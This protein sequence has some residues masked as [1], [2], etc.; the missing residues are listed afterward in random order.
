MW[1]FNIRKF[2]VALITLFKR[3]KTM[4]FNDKIAKRSINILRQL[5]KN[6][7]KVSMLGLGC[8][9]MSEFYGKIDPVESM[10]TLQHAYK[11]GCNFFDT[12]NM[13]GAGHNERL[14]GAFL[15]NKPRDT[16]VLATKCGIKTGE[17]DRTKRFIDNSPEHIKKSCDESLM[18]LGLDY[19]DLYYIHRIADGGKGI[20]KSMEAMADLLAEGKIRY[21]GLSEANEEII[22]KANAALLKATDGKHQ[23]TAIQTEYSLMSRGPEVDGVLN[24]CHELGIGFVPY[25]A[26][27]RQFLTGSVKNAKDYEKG[28]FRQSLPRFQEEN[29][30]ENQLVIEQL[31][32]VAK[33]KG[34]TMAQLSLAWVLAQDKQIVPIPGTKRVKYFDDN[35]GAI[36]VELTKEDLQNIDEIAPFKVFKG[37]R[38]TEQSMKTYGLLTEEEKFEKYVKSS[39]D[40]KNQ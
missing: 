33:G 25:G 17:V 35:W 19:I 20:E 22:R 21:V 28:D 32:E 37:W 11:I 13:Y 2:W 18:R 26:L 30:K 4:L 3:R 38:Y 24:A 10:R 15:K 29:F 1:K 34:C 7:P 5:G 16:Y 8:M 27:G 31:G 14:L 39:T 9:G 6:G 23:L 40:Y 36:K 12:A